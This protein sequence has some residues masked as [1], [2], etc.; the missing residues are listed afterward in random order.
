MMNTSGFTN[1]FGALQ[2]HFID[3]YNDPPSTISWIGSIQIFL[4]FF[5]G[6]FSGRFTDAGYFRVTFLAGSLA[7]VVGIFAAS[8]GSKLWVMFLTLGLG[9][10]LGNGL[11]S[12]PMV[13]VMSPY[14]SA[15]RGLAMGITMCGSCTGALVYSAIM[16]QLIPTLGFAWTMRVIAL[17]QLMTLGMANICLR[18]R[19]KGRKFPGWVDW[20]A[21][22]DVRF[23][24]YTTAIFLSLLGLYISIFFVVDFSRTSISPPFSYQKAMDLLLI[25]NGVN[26]IGRLGSGLAA[27]RLGVLKTFVPI[28]VATS[29][30]LLLWIPVRTAPGMYTWTV[31][32]GIFSGGIQSLF[33]AGLSYLTAGTEKPGTR[34]GMVFGLG[35]VASLI[36][37]PIGGALIGAMNGKY[38][39][40]QIFAGVTMALSALFLEAARRADKARI[41]NTVA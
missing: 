38:L 26:L 33:P 41:K 31:F 35:S 11:M 40:T 34:M 19:M 7:N 8:F 2:S 39:G 37:S 5:L 12:C 9:V 14:F 32:S 10:G 18:P 13:A 4:Y 24:H 6:V 23:N 21:F 3:T 16:R 28:L 22:G 15:R 20:T 36:G 1:S 30:T 27:D 29:L 17:I 25:F